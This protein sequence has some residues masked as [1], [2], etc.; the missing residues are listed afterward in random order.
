M[1]KSYPYTS[2]VGPDGQE[3]RLYFAEDVAEEN[4]SWFTDGVHPVP[5]NGLKV[6]PSAGMNVAIS[7]GVARIQGRRMVICDEPEIV[8]INPADLGFNRR[9]IIVIQHNGITRQARPIYRAGTPSSA[10][11]KPSLIRNDDIWEIQLCVIIVRAGVTSI[12]ASDITDT[13]LDPSVCGMS[14]L[15]VSGLPALEAHLSNLTTQQQTNFTTQLNSQQSTWQS[16]LS[17]QE[18][19]YQNQLNNQ[20]NGFNQQKSAIDAWYDNMRANIAVRQAMTFED[21]KNLAGTKYTVDILG[22]LICETV[23]VISSNR[24]IASKVTTFTS[25]KIT[26]ITDFYDQSLTPLKSTHTEINT[27]TLEEVTTGQ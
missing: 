13:R 3:D 23:E 16:Q 27:N 1:I 15:A 12:S 10:A 20:A 22:D 25:S 18:T 4:Q 21:V 7:L 26:I 9:D 8:A 6:L 5:A 14:T 11:T 17:R 24:A 2:E 19:Q